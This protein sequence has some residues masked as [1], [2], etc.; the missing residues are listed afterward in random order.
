LLLLDVRA[1]ISA[2]SSTGCANCTK[3]CSSLTSP[4]A[5]NLPPW[6]RRMAFQ[7]DP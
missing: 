5:A 3:S 6:H 2:S 4:A 1:C 7:T